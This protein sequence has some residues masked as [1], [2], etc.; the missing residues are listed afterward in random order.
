LLQEN[1][2]LTAYFDSTS[3]GSHIEHYYGIKIE[4]IYKRAGFKN[5]IVTTTHKIAAGMS[6]SP[7]YMNGKLLGALAY[8]HGGSSALS[9][10]GITPIE[11]MIA[12]ARSSSDSNSSGR[13]AQGWPV[14]FYYQGILFAPIPLENQ[15][16]DRM[17]GFVNELSDLGLSTDFQSSQQLASPTATNYPNNDEILAQNLGTSGPVALKAGMP[18]V[19]DLIEWQ[20]KNNETTTIGSLGTITY[21]DDNGRIYAFG[22]PFLDVKK[23][24][25]RFRTAS[26]LTTVESD[27][28]MSYKMAGKTSDVLGTIDYDSTY[29]IYGRVSLEG[30]DDLHHFNLEF[31]RNGKFVNKF[32]V[33]VADAVVTSNLMTQTFNSIGRIYG[34]PLSQE[35]SV[36][37]LEAIFS[38][39]GYKSITWNESF[40][41]T[42]TVLGVNIFYSSSYS[43]AIESM[44][45]NIF[46]PIF[47]SNYRFSF[48]E[49][50]VTVNFVPGQVQ[51]LKVG[52]IVVPGKVIWGKDLIFN[53]LLVAEYNSIALES[54]IKVE[55]DWDKV[56]KPVY[57]LD[58]KDLDKMQEKRV[59][60][61]IDIYGSAWVDEHFLAQQNLDY[62]PNFYLNAEDYLDATSKWLGITS[63]RLFGRAIFRAEDA[64]IASGVSQERINGST[65]AQLNEWKI[66]P[67]GIK[68]KKTIP[69]NSHRITFPI[70]FPKVPSGSI[71]D[72]DI[73]IEVMFEVVLEK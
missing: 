2:Y 34:A 16:F 46:V 65:A 28:G 72:P 10:G 19:V 11:L 21:I 44:L 61:S 66:I 9:W 17:T 1:D 48:E 30:I 27:T 54:S 43:N 22:H 32:S 20:D 70:E 33:K 52:S 47:S 55:V 7:V 23:V 50:D 35:Q 3:K 59:P 73:H 40:M 4:G 51:V 69:D 64:N 49:I 57:T 8:H 41:P 71:V 42:K 56:Q 53:I 12:E 60:G 15:G 36:T 63:Q 68:E 6:G 67:E 29:G 24:R 38:V 37:E 14:Q 18:I 58:T 39:R 31:K 45:S 13:V 62:R 25:Y 26:I 5:I